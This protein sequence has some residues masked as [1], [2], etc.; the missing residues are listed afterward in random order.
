MKKNLL[1]IFVSLLWLLKSIE[2]QNVKCQVAMDL[3]FIV[4]SSGSIGIDSFNKSKT[5]IKN[6]VDR[7]NIGENNAIIGL[8]NYSSHVETILSFILQQQTWSQDL[9]KSKIDSMKYLGQSTATGDALHTSRVSIFSIT[10]GIVPR[11][12]IV[13]TDGQS[14]NAA[15]VANEAQLLKD[16][17]VDIFAVGIGN[18][19]NNAELETIAS[20]PKSTFKLHISG[21]NALF[22]A[23]NNITQVACNTNAFIPLFT[24][25]QVDT[26]VNQQKYFQ[27]NLESFKK[28]GYAQIKVQHYKGRTNIYYSTREKNPNT[29]NPIGRSASLKNTN[30]YLVYIP[31]GTPRLYLT[32]H[33]IEELNQAEFQ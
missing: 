20:V 6:M 16:E 19:I 2:S 30:E 3:V 13:L 27:A 23:I 14:N 17:G 24:L 31:A 4:D 1:Q 32:T 12:A 29:S 5:A 33:G 25:I 8:I 10:R 15:Q 7:F 18:G 28:G 26:V 21:Y 9:V 11:L 22:D